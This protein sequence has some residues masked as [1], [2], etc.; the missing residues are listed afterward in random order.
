LDY[1]KEWRCANPNEVGTPVYRVLYEALSRSLGPLGTADAN[2]QPAE[3]ALA[4]LNE[5]VAQAEAL[6]RRITK[7]SGVKV[8]STASRGRVQIL[9]WRK[10]GDEESYCR[11]EVF[12]T[13]DITNTA[14]MVEKEYNV[15]PGAEDEG[16]YDATYYVND[17]ITIADG[18]IM[19]SHDGRRF[20]IGV[21][22]AE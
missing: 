5:F 11:V 12:A 3:V 18:D 13:D 14:S 9:N 4:S 22:L 15:R 6:R 21:V 17:D 1:L 7:A 10:H 2:A 19:V 20:R 8:A 16:D